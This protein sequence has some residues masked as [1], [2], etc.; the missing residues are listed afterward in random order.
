MDLWDILIVSFSCVI[1]IFKMLQITQQYLLATR[2]FG[3]NPFSHV[4]MNFMTPDQ[5]D[6]SRPRLNPLLGPTQVKLW[7]LEALHMDQGIGV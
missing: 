7:Q 4:G 6:H 2:I 1:S 5:G 3:H